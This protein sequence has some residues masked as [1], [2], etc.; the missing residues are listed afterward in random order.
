MS[1]LALNLADTARSIH[2]HPAAVTDAATMTYAD[3]HAESSR[4]ATLLQ[5]N[6]IG[7]GDRGVMLPNTAAVVLSCGATVDPQEL[8]AFAERRVAAY[9]YPRRIWLVDNLPTGKLL[10]RDVIPP[11]EEV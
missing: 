6:G 3:L 2:A 4:F 5:R 7:A 9:R 1:N 11:P 8:R 10:R